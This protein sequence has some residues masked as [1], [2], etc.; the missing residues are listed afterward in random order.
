MF[1][2]S[3]GGLVGKGCGR[4]VVQVHHA[5]VVAVRPV[6]AVAIEPLSCFPGPSLEKNVAKQ[7]G[8]VAVLRELHRLAGMRCW[9]RLRP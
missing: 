5:M 1:S 9:P 8:E 3:S 4:Q 2:F 6:A 7:T